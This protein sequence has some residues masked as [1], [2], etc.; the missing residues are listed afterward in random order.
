MSITKTER[1][2]LREMKAEDAKELSKV[3]SDPE[4]MRYSLKGVHTETQIH[5][6]INNSIKL[7]KINGYGP[8]V[9]YNI[10]SGEFVGICGLNK[11]NI[12]NDE[13]VHIVYRLAKTQQ[14]K[15]YATEASFGVLDFAKKSLSLNHIH[16]LI[17]PQNTDSLKVAQRAGF[18]FEKSSKFSNVNIEVYQAQL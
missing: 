4:V 8:W 9:I 14:G 15:G 16:A 3:L 6:Y 11:H 12:D 7:Y 5:D 10:I 2:V 18:K 13:L 1:L 17:E